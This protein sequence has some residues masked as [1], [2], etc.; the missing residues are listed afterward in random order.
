MISCTVGIAYFPFFLVDFAADFL[1]AL[2]LAAGRFAAAFFAPPRAAAFF[3]PAREAALRVVFAPRVPRPSSAGF[4]SPSAGSSFSPS[5]AD[6][7]RTTSDQ[8]MWYVETSAYG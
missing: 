8:R 7:M 5:A 4:S 3:A 1:A 6:S 2:F